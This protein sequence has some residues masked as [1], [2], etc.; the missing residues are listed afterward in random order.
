M[1]TSM[2]I[3]QLFC[4]FAFFSITMCFSSNLLN[5]VFDESE[6]GEFCL[7]VI[8]SRA[9]NEIKLNTTHVYNSASGIL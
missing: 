5:E 2:R 3:C 7:H 4:V 9:G 8:Q 1:R 6:S